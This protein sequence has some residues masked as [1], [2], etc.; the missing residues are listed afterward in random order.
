MTHCVLAELVPVSNAKTLNPFT[1]RAAKTGLTILEIFIQQKHFGKY[2]KTKCYL[3]VRQQLS[4]NFFVTF[5]FI[6]KLF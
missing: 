1:L 3:E 5:S 4:F 6:H 2:L